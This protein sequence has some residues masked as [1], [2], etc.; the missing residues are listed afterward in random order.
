LLQELIQ[1]Q[2]AV[3]DWD[4]KERDEFNHIHVCAKKSAATISMA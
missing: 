3:V 2:F 1:A 4:V